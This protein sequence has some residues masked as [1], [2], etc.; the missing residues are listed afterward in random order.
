M[1]LE[2]TLKLMNIYVQDNAKY[3]DDIYMGMLKDYSS[4]EVII[5]RYSLDNPIMK[6]LQ[7]GS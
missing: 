6:D 4:Q 7:I 1:I 3:S 2:G 5:S